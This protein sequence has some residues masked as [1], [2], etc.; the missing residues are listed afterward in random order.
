MNGHDE[1]WRVINDILQKLRD[2]YNPQ[3][4]ILFGSFASGN[5]HPDSDIDILIIKETSDR[6]IDRCTAV[7]RLLSDPGRKIPLEILVLTPDE[8]SRRLAAGDQFISDITEKG[9]LLYAA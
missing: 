2:N 1:V 4:V 9:N 6:F 5:P 3:K 8:I 7:R